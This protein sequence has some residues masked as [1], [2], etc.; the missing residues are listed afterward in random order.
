MRLSKGF[1]KGRALAVG[2]AALAA[3]CAT[4]EEPFRPKAPAFAGPPVWSAPVEEIVVD[5]LPF[6]FEKVT[7]ICVE[8]V[9]RSLQA[10]TKAGEDSAARFLITCLSL[11]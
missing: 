6:L 5:Q 11:A 8:N 1:S 4:A 9:R 2:L 10:G 3:A 7:N